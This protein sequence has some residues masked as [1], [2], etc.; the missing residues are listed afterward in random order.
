M[1]NCERMMSVDIHTHLGPDRFSY[2]SVNIDNYGRYVDTL[3]EHMDNNTIKHAV[4]VPPSPELNDLYYEAASIYPERLLFA[5][6][7]TPRPID[8]TLPLIKEKAN[9]DCKAIVL[10]ERI[11]CPQDPAVLAIVNMAIEQDLAVYIHA[12]EI[13]FDTLSFLDRVTRIYPDGKFII[14]HMG[15]LFGFYNILSLLSRGNI[16]LE[17]SMTLIKLVESPLRVFLDALIQDAGVM[18]L[19]FGSEH[20][21]DYSDIF[22]ILNIINLNVETRKIITEENARR[23]LK[24][25]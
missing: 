5:H 6:T 9:N 8:Y 21:A 2:E 20:Y 14:T 1:K 16:W 24:I 13:S 22:A 19:V 17:T 23:L 18:Y 7:V 12:K 15:G 10:D 25:K 3:I 11:L 4:L